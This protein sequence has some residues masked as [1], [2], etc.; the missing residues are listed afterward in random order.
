MSLSKFY[1]VVLAMLALTLSTSISRAEYN[2]IENPGFEQGDGNSVTPWQHTG[3]V[4][5]VTDEVFAG[6]YAL[7]I[8]A[9]GDTS[10]IK[11]NWF[12]VP[13]HAQIDL[14]AWMKAQD[15]VDSGSY[16]K[17]RVSLTAYAAD[18]ETEIDTWDL[19][20]TEGS[21]DWKK[22]QGTIL[23]PPETKY[24]QFS[25][26][27]S[28]T[29]G[30]FWIDDVNVRIVQAVP[31]VDMSS[32][33]PPLILPQPWQI[34]TDQ[35]TLPIQKVIVHAI[36][37]DHHVKAALR[38]L[39]NEQQITYQWIGEAEANRRGLFS[40]Q[41]DELEQPDMLARLQQ[42]FPTVQ[43]SD[44][45]SQG[46]FLAVDPG[47]IYLGANTEQ[48]RFYGLQTL[49]Q[50]FDPTQAAIYRAAI[51]DY[52]LLTRRGI[53][54]GKPWFRD[55]EEMFSRLA[56]NKLN[57][58]WVQGTFLED[59]LWY[60]WRD[61]FTTEDERAL[62]NL[63]GQAKRNFVDLYISIGPRGEDAA[64]HTVYSS[65]QEIDLLFAKM[66]ALHKMGLRNFGLSFDD[67]EHFEQDRLYGADV[68]FFNN[69]IGEAHVYFATRI[70]E[71][72][73]RYD[74]NIHFMIVPM[75]YHQLSNRGDEDEAYLD[76]L[77]HLPAGVELYTSVE[78]PEDARL[79]IEITGR[80]HLVWDN[81]WANAYRDPAPDFVVPLNRPNDLNDQLIAG[82][83]FM[84]LIPS[85][86]GNARISWKTAADYAWAPARYSA[87][88][89][90][91]KAAIQ[92]LESNAVT[93]ALSS[94]AQSQA[95]AANDVNTRQ[96]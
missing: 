89:S 5:R 14:S 31:T 76:A 2:L 69:N 40:L 90:F 38:T 29:T 35:T 6:N 1:A 82:Y 54:A 9:S 77:R 12:E 10:K 63:M 28:Q 18:Q 11:S 64:T 60:N 8:S 55:S 47:K 78:S 81:L 45:G 91:Q 50:L 80:R 25:A 86:E 96:E 67:L 27:L 79:A 57:F 52:P 17:L 51:A 32:V 68:E 95:L 16:Y 75:D 48:G 21:F 7:K 94:A 72:L 41:I 70:Y 49:R 42:S 34:Q 22:I 20:A 65:D 83:T 84:P 3:S 19:V 43:P 56:A 33:E 39:L 23:V 92:Y 30:T 44:L 13:P 37:T 59:R 4:E 62:R 66:T 61:P 88:V 71:R 93:N 36:A 87:G 53:A 85:L 26:Q 46:Y 73:K 24:M 74:P 58:V 15:V